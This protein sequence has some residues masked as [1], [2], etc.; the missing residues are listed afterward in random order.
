M[1]IEGVTCRQLRE[2]ADEVAEQYP[3]AT[4]VKNPVGNLSVVQDG[5]YLG[6]LDL[7]SGGVEWLEDDDPDEATETGER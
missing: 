1:S 3:D 6:W 5:V 4:L 2:M 7:H